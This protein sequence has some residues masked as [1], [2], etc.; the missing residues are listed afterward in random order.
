MKIT[1]HTAIQEIIARTSA[2]ALVQMICGL[3]FV[4]D[5][6]WVETHA[7]DGEA[8]TKVH[9][10]ADTAL[11]EAQLELDRRIPKRESW[12]TFDTALLKETT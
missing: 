3:R 2:S 6:G 4:P 10:A 12:D 7:W 1:N 8:P 11:Q 5:R 9:L